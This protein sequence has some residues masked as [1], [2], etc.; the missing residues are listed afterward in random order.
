MEQV[1][2]A[3]REAQPTIIDEL[4]NRLIDQHIQPYASLP[5]DRLHQL[6]S[7]V[8]GAV[9]CDLAEDST[10]NFSS[11]WEKVASVRAEQGGNINEILQAVALGEEI[12]DAHMRVALAGDAEL[13]AW[14][15]YR[16][17]K[18]LYAGVV[19]LSNV[20]I[21]AHEQLIQNQAF[22]IRQLSTPLMP[23]YTGV[24]VL[25]LV[26]AIDTYRASQIMEVLL[27][28]IARAQA[29]VVIIDITGVPL[30]D[31]GVSNSLIQAARAAQLLG[32]RVVLVGISAEIAQ[33]MVQLGIDLTHLTIR[34]N[35]QS[36][37]EYAFDLQGFAIKSKQAR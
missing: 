6:S 31:T 8:V 21:N 18:I 30:V 35:L 11:Y 16:L 22:Q 32:T 3:F 12:M 2:S 13:R 7:S 4:T 15:S 1:I 26:G 17:H 14:W 28:G 29:E 20:F 37:I 23:L 10:R 25:P 9:A 19:T 36:G 33:T 27:E 5:H 24:L 34:A